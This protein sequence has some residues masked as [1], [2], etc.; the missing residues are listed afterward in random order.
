MKYRLEYD[1]AA[2]QLL[3]RLPPDL[4]R[5]IRHAV[6]SL[7][8]DPH[9]GKELKLELEGYRSLRTRRYRV[10]YRIRENDHV[11]EI[12]HLGARR[13]IYDAFRQLLQRRPS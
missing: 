8:T 12:H 1:A 6:E 11:V 3:R 5:L 10:I 7:Q 9:Q 2:R 13:D 4:K